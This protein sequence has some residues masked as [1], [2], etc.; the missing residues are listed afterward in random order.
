MLDAAAK[1]PY[2]YNDPGL[3]DR[4]R[5][6]IYTRLVF[7][8][9]LLAATVFIGLK[10]ESNLM[11]ISVVFIFI[12]IGSTILASFI[13]SFFLFL[14]GK[15][16]IRELVILSYSHILWDALFA[17]AVLYITG[18]VDS[19][20][21]ILYYIN[22]VL[23]SILMFKKGGFLAASLSSI[24]YG[25]IIVSEVHGILP[26]FY[27]LNFSLRNI[28]ETQV[29]AKL[30]INFIFFFFLAWISSAFTEKLRKTE[31]LLEEKKRDL[32]NLENFNK[33]IVDNLSS[34]LL[35]LDN[36]NR[37]ISYNTA[38]ARILELEDPEMVGKNLADIFSD[39]GSKILAEYEEN[40]FS[41]KYLWRWESTY[42]LKDER[43]LFIGLNLVPFSIKGLLENGKIVVFEDL[44]SYREMEERV[45]RSE[46]FAAIGEL[47]AGIAHEIRNPLTSMSGA[48]EMLKQ[49]EVA[50]NGKGK[51]MDIVFRETT[52]LNY[53]I[54]DFLNF[55]KSPKLSKEV[56]DANVLIEETLELF[57]K[58]RTEQDKTVIEKN[59]CEHVYISADPLQIKQVI[60][61]LLKN[62]AQAMPEGGKISVRAFANQETGE[63]EISIKDS[64]IG[65]VPEDL[66][67]IF[68]PFFTTK[69]GGTGLGLATVHR[70]IEDHSG[71]VS[72]T[73]NPGMGA[74]FKVFLPL[75]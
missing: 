59:L 52:R 40:K 22:I 51:L 5:V 29:L 19:I 66:K 58:G 36:E 44:T 73:S 67:R 16:K 53:L 21:Y 31:I 70:I 18:G 28:N 61:N 17:T 74:E 11:G 26:Q 6:L 24:C 75:N 33:A 42:L 43:K 10:D 15:E 50:G 3:H 55:A 34:G 32:K 49:D 54:S 38:A 47:A 27:D 23:A 30:L 45:K 64:G 71:R 8:S 39:A 69:K 57:L 9:I 65:I 68:S 60:W 13:F 35:T 20:F 63:F 12:L 72:V 1:A 14:I 2:K 48:I 46:K 41:Q 7:I 25:L 4:L 56:F 37:V 62:S